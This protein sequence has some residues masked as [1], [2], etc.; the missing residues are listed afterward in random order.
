MSASAHRHAISDLLDL[1]G[2]RWALRVLWELREEPMTFGALRAACG[3]MSTSVLSDRLADLRDAHLVEQT[4]G[5]YALTPT[6]RELLTHLA[7]L[8]A[9]ARRWRDEG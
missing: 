2:R 3:E 8:N 4:G 1:L 7:P 5:R 9:F 6:G